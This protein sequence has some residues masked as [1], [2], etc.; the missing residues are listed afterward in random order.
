MTM[1]VIYDDLLAICKGEKTIK[2]VAKKHNLKE[3]TI[4]KYLY[5]NKLYRHKTPVE[6]ISPFTNKTY[7]SIRECADDLGVSSESV[8]SALK[9]N[10]VKCL[11][12]LDIL[13]KRVKKW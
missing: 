1:N 6:V 7:D 11:D 5:I 10:Y 13:I 2:Q 12:E 4:K 9:G 3:D 8:R